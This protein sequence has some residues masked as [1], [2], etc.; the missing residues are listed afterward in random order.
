MT[1]PP[2]TSPCYKLEFEVKWIQNGWQC[3]AKKTIYRRRF[4]FEYLINKLREAEVK[5]SRGFTVVQV[6]KKLE[7]TT[8]LIL[9]AKA[10]AKRGRSAH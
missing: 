9:I 1:L 7:V 8:D 10:I 4:T 5:L 2:K 3:N 6:C